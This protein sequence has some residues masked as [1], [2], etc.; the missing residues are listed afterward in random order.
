MDLKT[1]GIVHFL[2]YRSVQARH[3]HEALTYAPDTAKALLV[4]SFEDRDIK[5]MTNAMGC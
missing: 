3:L 4:T 1:G 5:P 2:S